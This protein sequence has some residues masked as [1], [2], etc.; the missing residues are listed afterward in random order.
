MRDNGMV[1]SHLF[2]DGAEVRIQL[3]RTL[4]AKTR[5]PII[6]QSVQLIQDRMG[7]SED[8]AY[9]HLFGGHAKWAEEAS[10]AIPAGLWLVHDEGCYLLSNAEPFTPGVA[11]ALGLNPHTDGEGVWDAARAAVGGDD[12]TCF[13][14]ASDFSEVGPGCQVLL[15]VS[16]DHGSMYGGSVSVSVQGL[17]EPP[18]CTREQI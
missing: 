9:S 1:T 18:S 14:P 5:R 16:L 15:D 12:F 13:L 6:E 11:F 10:A 4:Q 8:E 17:N 2:F 7:C 3:D